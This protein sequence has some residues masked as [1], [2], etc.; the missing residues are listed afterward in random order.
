MNSNKTNKFD[1]E[2]D[3]CL[4]IKRQCVGFTRRWLYMNK[5]MVYQDVNIAADIW[6]TVNHYT[7]ITDGKK[8]KVNNIENGATQL[9]KMGDLIIYSE[10]FLN[11]G[12]VSVVVHVNKQHKSI[13]LYEQNFKNKF[14]S[15]N[16]QRSISFVYHQQCFWL[17]D[18]YLLGWKRIQEVTE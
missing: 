18:R 2:N 7:R 3:H 15:P 6:D 12:H 16:Q 10:K 8:I 17:L 13:E 5:G 1:T 11:T 14:Q 9:P 4:G